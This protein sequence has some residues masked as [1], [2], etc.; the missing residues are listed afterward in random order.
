MKFWF[1]WAF[2][3]LG[4]AVFV[5]LLYWTGLYGGF[6]FDDFVNFLEPEE[7][8]IKGLSWNALSGAWDSGHAGPL[9]RPIS[10][11]SF[12]LNHYFSGFVPFYFKLTNVVIHLLNGLLVYLLVHLIARAMGQSSRPVGVGPVVALML[13]VAWAIHPIQMTSVLYVVQRMTSLSSMFMLIG[14][15][16]HIWA[17]QLRPFDKRGLWALVVAWGVAFPMA[18]LSKETGV[19]FVGYVFAYELI[20][21]RHFNRGF[22]RPATWFLSSLSVSGL[23]FLAYLSFSSSWLFGGYEERAFSLFERLIT[24]ARIVWTYLGMIF[25]PSLTDFSLYHDDFE[26]SKGLLQPASTLL[27]VAGIF[28]LF[29]I[30]WQQR[31]KRPLIAFAIAWFLIGHSLESTVFPLELMHEHRNYLPSLALVFLIMHIV[32]SPSIN[33][34]VMRTAMFGGGMAM[35]LYFGLLTYLRADMY[36]NDFRRTQIEA[37]YHGGSTRAQYEAGALMVNLYN[38]QRSPMYR[39]VMFLGLANKHFEQVNMLDPGFKLG[40][41]G[42]LQLDCLSE[43]TARE[44]TLSELNRRFRSGANRV[45][46]RTALS[47]IVRMTNDGTICLSRD[48][49]DQ[50]FLGALSNPLVY[51]NKK[52]RILT[53]YAVY[54]WL[55]QKDYAAALAALDQAYELNNDDIENRLNAIQLFRIMG[56]KESVLSILAY[57]DGMKLARRDRDNLAEI[58]EELVRDGVLSTD[59]LRR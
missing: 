47:G 8:R 41:V 57:L 22:D 46:D 33:T 35:L 18:L 48:Q 37:Q 38:D 45:L 43:K 9:G 25:V 7:I 30:A 28:V 16:L 42:M 27:A 59:H 6:F 44:Q 3:V 55:G 50:L 19:L 4:M 54:L 26:I 29:L 11:L 12:A 52:S 21:R 49:V 34:P 5:L 17:R 40:L 24:E 1:R 13:A 56:D 31:I 53:V 14:L 58:K 23:A 15:V 32:L 20:I 36:G 51:G 39:S 10:M 2:P